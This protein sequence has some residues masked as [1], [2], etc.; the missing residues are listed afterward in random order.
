MIAD[1]TQVKAKVS[2]KKRKGSQ[3]SDLSE[4]EW[5]EQEDSPK[6][7]STSRTHTN[8]EKPD[9]TSKT[10]SKAVEEGLICNKIASSPTKKPLKENSVLSKRSKPEE[11]D[12]DQYDDEDI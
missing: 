12:N 6:K 7:G 4:I 3:S 5:S 1:K 8:H 10:N 9:P 11:S 2:M